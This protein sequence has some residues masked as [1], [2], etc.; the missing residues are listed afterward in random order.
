MDSRVQS[1]LSFAAVV[2]SIAAAVSALPNPAIALARAMGNV[3]WT[4]QG[5][6]GNKEYT[7]KPA[8]FRRSESRNRERAR[9]KARSAQRAISRLRGL[10]R[11]H[12]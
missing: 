1:H 2:A 6:S 7:K 4:G 11:S 9:R 5:G 12:P 10:A 8:M 3:G